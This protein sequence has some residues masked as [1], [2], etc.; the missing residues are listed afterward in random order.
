MHMYFIGVCEPLDSATCRQKTFTGPYATMQEWKEAIC[1]YNEFDC[2]G[3]AEPGK[4]IY[5]LVLIIGFLLLL[6]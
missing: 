4:L 3:L 1:K 2:H 6:L 5:V